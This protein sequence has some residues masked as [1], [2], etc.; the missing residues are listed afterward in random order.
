MFRRAGHHQ[1]G[2]R[3][4]KAQEDTTVWT[5]LPSVFLAA[6]TPLVGSPPCETA[7]STRQAL[8]AAIRVISKRVNLYQGNGVCWVFF[9]R[10][11]VFILLFDSALELNGGLQPLWPF[12]YQ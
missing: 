3:S 2:R 9:L 1:G 6:E 12:I 11:S 4:Q 7:P 10:F 5:L 8:T